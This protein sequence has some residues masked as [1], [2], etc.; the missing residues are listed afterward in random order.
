MTFDM[1][2]QT[3]SHLTT[4]TSSAHDDLGAEVRKLYDAAAPLEGRFNGAG[5]AAFN[6]FKADTDQIATDLNT[7][8]AG[9][10]A[11]IDGQ[12]VAFL[13]GEQQMADETHTAHS[14]AG[15]EAARFSSTV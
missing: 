5:R 2:A 13:T 6:Q 8:L 15:F 4:A 14:G 12:N 1:G 3:L 10:L 9:V 11:G 7:A